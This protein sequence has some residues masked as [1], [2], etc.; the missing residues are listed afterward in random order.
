MLTEHKWCHTEHTAQVVLLSV[1]L[2]KLAQSV[3]VSYKL[4]TSNTVHE[5]QSSTVNTFR[6]SLA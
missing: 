6:T 5:T 3:T 4:V 2:C 1:D